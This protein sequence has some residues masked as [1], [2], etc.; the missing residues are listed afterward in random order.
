MRTAR[1]N[2]TVAADILV[3]LRCARD[4]THA[5]KRASRSRRACLRLPSDAVR[6]HEFVIDSVVLAFTL[7][8][9][10]T[11]LRKS[12]RDHVILEL[13]KPR[14]P[15]SVVL[16]WDA[17]WGVCLINHISENQQS[18][19]HF[20]CAC[21]RTGG[22][23]FRNQQMEKTWYLVCLQFSLGCTWRLRQRQTI[24]GKN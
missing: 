11:M 5:V 15:Q 13:C 20:I 8:R 18:V 23:W 3:R 24:S 16:A 2:E 7:D 4:K 17:R 9:S 10:H 14:L 21:A 6:R 22:Q 19:F 12:F 1:T